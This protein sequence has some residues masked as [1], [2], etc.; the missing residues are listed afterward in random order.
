MRRVSVRQAAATTV[1]A[2][3]W[4]VAACGGDTSVGGDQPWTMAVDSS[5]DTIRVQITGDVPERLVRSLV[6]ELRVGAVDGSEEETFGSIEYVRGTA[7]GGV[8]VYD[9]QAQALRRFDARGAF[10]RRIGGKGGGPGE[11]GHVNGLA[12][13]PDGR[14]AL[15]DAP[16]AR[17]NF[18]AAGG[19]FLTSVSLPIT[20]WFMQDGL[21][22][23]RSGMLYAWA[24][25]E[26]APNSFTVSKAGYVRFD[27][28]AAVQDTLVWPDWGVKETV[29]T[30]SSADGGSS[31][32]TTVP[33]A[34]S[35]QAEFHPAG[36]IVSAPGGEPYVWYRL[37]E[38]SKPLRVERSHT[39]VP[40]SSTEASERRAQI[41]R[42]MKRLSP[43]WNW[44]GPAIP[45][46]K[47]AIRGLASGVDGRVWVRVYTPGEAIPT[48]QL[49]PLQDIPN[50]PIRLTTREPELW[51]V[52]S[53]DGQLLAR[54]RPPARTRLLSFNGNHAWGVQLDSLDVPYAVRFR[55]EPALS[56]E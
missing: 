14:W 24:M 52:F 51:D 25:L 21:H 34:P 33:W 23:D 30:A 46:A 3:L 45:A 28:A 19:D 15:W 40:V 7:E 36:G 37:V 42:T 29:L 13:L 54:V 11:H 39:P 18:Y 17:V 31:T 32:A 4:A 6:P 12:L 53:V 35:A 56:P 44:T 48:E 26:R 8:L 16:G 55:I 20:G 2:V 41:E 50:P 10:A 38:G 49:A 1:A 22:A 43:S 9:G 47:P 27:S 5:G